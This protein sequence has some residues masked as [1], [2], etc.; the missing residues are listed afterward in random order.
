[1]ISRG[2]M[3]DFDANALESDSIRKGRRRMH[4]E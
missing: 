2:R 3:R 1:M 4:I